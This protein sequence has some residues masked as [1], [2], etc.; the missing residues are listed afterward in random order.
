MTYFYVSS[1]I[2]FSIL[3][4]KSQEFFYQYVNKYKMEGFESFIL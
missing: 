2:I 1:Y 4:H 3:L